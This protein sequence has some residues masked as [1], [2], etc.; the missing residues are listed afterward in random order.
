[1]GNYRNPPK[2]A[3]TSQRVHGLLVSQLQESDVEVE[4][5]IVTRARATVGGTTMDLDLVQK[6]DRCLVENA[7]L[8]ALRG[9]GIEVLNL[10]GI[11]GR[12]SDL[13]RRTAH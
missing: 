7:A 4:L 2:T 5:A 3:M 13:G 6:C 9:D 11:G 12:K 10:P 1:M 8:I